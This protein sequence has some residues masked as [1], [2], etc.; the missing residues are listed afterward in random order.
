MLMVTESAIVHGLRALGLNS[1]SAII[2]H[3]SLRSFGEVSGAHS[4][5]AKL[6]SPLEPRFLC[7]LEVGT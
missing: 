4:L 1:S 3:A 5:S 2:V 6:F 7:L